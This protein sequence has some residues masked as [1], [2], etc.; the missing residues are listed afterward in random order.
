MVFLTISLAFGLFESRTGVMACRMLKLKLKVGWA[1]RRSHMQ[2]RK[3]SAC[4]IVSSSLG[5]FFLPTE[6]HKVNE[7]NPNRI[8]LDTR[9]SRGHVKRSRNK[10]ATTSI[11]LCVSVLASPV[12][13]ISILKY[14]EVQG[15]VYQLK[16]K[17]IYPTLRPLN[18]RYFFEY[19][20]IFISGSG[21]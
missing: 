1:K 6:K 12:L 10:T 2:V 8:T 21:L 16:V 17:L 18:R 14:A 5:C 3:H 13:R 15:M 11:C 4:F 20:I 7:I 9:F 19:C